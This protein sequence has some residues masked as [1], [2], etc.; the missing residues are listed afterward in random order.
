MASIREVARIAGVSPSTVSRVMNG[1]ANVEESKREKVLRAIEETGFKPNELARA[2][3]KQSSK[4]IG[5]IVPNIENAFFGELARAAEEEAYRNGYKILL[6]NSNNNTEK[7]LMNIQ[8]LNQ[9]KADGIIIITNND[10]TGKEIA[11]CEFPVVVVDR[12]LTGSGESAG[13]ESD[14]YKGGI[15]ATEH[16][17]ECGCRNIV[18]LR[19]PLEVS[20]GQQ[21]YRGY[22]A[23]CE[24]HG[25]KEQYID[26]IYDYEYGLEATKA[27]LQK[28]PNVDGIIACNDM[29][30]ISAYK[31][32]TQ[33]GYKVPEDIQIIGFD[34]IRLS[35]LLTPELTTVRQPIKE[36]GTLAVQIIVQHGKGLPFQKENIFDVELIERQ[37]TRRREVEG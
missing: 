22:L 36:M 23:V 1:T 9:M 37:T 12:K 7:E 2:L 21:R 13:I 11:K 17:I 28:Y 14:H 26:C 34:N 10:K 16:L 4:I 18:C 8:M 15:L 29:V 27:L 20:S 19:G 3:Y 6:C 5:I 33:T 35:W 24:K 32:L 30:A 25:I 31:T